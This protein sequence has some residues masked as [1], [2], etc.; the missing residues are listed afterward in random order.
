MA[1]ALC[2]SYATT[3]KMEVEGKARLEADCGS[4]CPWLHWNWSEGCLQVFCLLQ[5]HAARCSYYPET[6]ATKVQTDAFYHIVC[7]FVHVQI[8]SRSPSNSD[9]F[10]R[11]PFCFAAKMDRVLKQEVTCLSVMFYATTFVCASKAVSCTHENHDVFL[12]IIWCA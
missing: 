5:A 4:D 7:Y 3:V 11:C 10:L 8:P 2:S 6:V 12:V 1:I 9:S